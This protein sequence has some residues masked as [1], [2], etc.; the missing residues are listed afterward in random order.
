MTRALRR[1]VYIGLA[2]LAVVAGT[3]LPAGAHAGA[4]LTIHS[5]GAGSIWVTARWIDGHPVTGPATAIVTASSTTG[6]RVG[7]VALRTVDDGNGTLTYSGQLASGHWSV[8]AEMASPAVARCDTQVRVGRPAT[9]AT[10]T[11]T[12]EDVEPAAAPSGGG[13]S[14]PWPIIALVGAL[15]VVL[16]A[17]RLAPRRRRR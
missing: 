11:C 17:M 14:P 6:Q 8:T 1:L 13:S 3:G 2:T 5:D 12:P 16:L 7:P 15:G 9:P 10:V 4:V